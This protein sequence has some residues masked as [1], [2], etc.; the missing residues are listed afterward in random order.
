MAVA[1]PPKRM[2]SS[3]AMTTKG[4]IDATGLPPVT[5]FHCIAVQIVRRKPE[6]V[7]VRPPISVKSRTRLTGRSR[8]STSS[9]SWTGTGV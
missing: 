5:R 8:S 3:K 7:P 1:R 6:A 2:V 4:G 9:I